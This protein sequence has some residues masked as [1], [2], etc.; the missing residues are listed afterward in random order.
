MRETERDTVFSIGRVD[1]MR[2]VY[3]QHLPGRT[4]TRGRLAPLFFFVFLTFNEDI[5]LLRLYISN[6]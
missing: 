1:E 3:Q 6:P 5:R 2:T 4:E